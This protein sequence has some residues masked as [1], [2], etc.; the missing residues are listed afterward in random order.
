MSVQSALD[1]YAADVPYET[2]ARAF[3]EHDRWTGDDPRLLLAEAAASTTGQGFRAGIYPTVERFREAFVETGRVGSFADLAAID[4]ENEDLV[5]AFGAQ[6]KRRVLLEAAATLADRPEDDDLAGLEGWAAEADHYRYAEDPIG[7]IS[8]VGPATFQYLRQ[9]AG[10]DAVRPDPTV[11]AFLE[12]IAADLD[13]APIDTSEPRRTIASCEWLSLV[14]SYRPI[15]LDRIAWWRETDPED[16]TAV[17]AIRQ[18]DDL[19][20]A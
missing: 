4:L 9:L 3:L 15:D 1:R 5:A 13:S 8:G 18:P 6:R 12:D 7:S 17:L 16:R 20:P 2:L 19:E 10:V 14:S 11:V